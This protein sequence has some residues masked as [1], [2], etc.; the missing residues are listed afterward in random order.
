[1]KA[2]WVNFTAI[3]WHAWRK[4]RFQVPHTL[5]LQLCLPCIRV[6]GAT[7]L[8]PPKKT[9]KS[10]E[11]QVEV[12]RPS[13]CRRH[14]NT[15]QAMYVF[16]NIEAARSSN[17]CYSGKAVSIT[18]SECVF[19]DTGIQHAMRMRHIVMCGLLGS[20][21]FFLLI[22]YMARFFYFEHKMCFDF[23]YNFCL[24][25]FSF[26]EEVSKVWSKTYIGLHVNYPFFLS[27]FNETWFFSI[28]FW[29]VFK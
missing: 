26:Y 3:K 5:I 24:K 18:Y 11:V 2:I 20:T 27:D 28:E 15:R 16:R 13:P 10:V 14:Q 6:A 22:S 17:R 9:T 19:V 23:L 8:L 12:C 25:H 29:K 7:L 4:T 1:M 21:T